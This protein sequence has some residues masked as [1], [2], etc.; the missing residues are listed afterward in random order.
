M[1]VKQV[2]FQKIWKKY[3]LNNWD[4]GLYDYYITQIGMKYTI[5]KNS[6]VA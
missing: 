3:S 4:K 6:K 1:I 5:Y 2:M